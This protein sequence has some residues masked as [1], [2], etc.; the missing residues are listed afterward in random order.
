MRTADA[1]IEPPV[2]LELIAGSLSVLYAVAALLGFALLV[3]MFKI[4]L[5]GRID[6]LFYRGLVLVAVAFLATFGLLAVAL[7]WRRFGD[8]GPRDAFAAAALSLSLNFGFLVVVPVT[9]DRS[10]GIFISRPDGGAPGRGV[11]A[12]VDD[13]AVYERIRKRTPPD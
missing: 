10:I 11:H 4:R 12:R 1:F 2:I 7:S 3:V 5:L 6:I 9:V 8:L 13:G